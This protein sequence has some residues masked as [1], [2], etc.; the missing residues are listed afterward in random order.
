IG[1]NDSLE[2]VESVR[3][4]AGSL[5]RECWLAPYDTDGV[6]QKIDANTTRKRLLQHS[7][8]RRRVGEIAGPMEQQ[9]HLRQGSPGRGI[10]V[11]GQHGAACANESH[12]DRTSQSAART[13]DDD[14]RRVD[15]CHSG[16]RAFTSFSTSATVSIPSSS[17]SLSCRPSLSS[18]ATTR[19]T[20]TTE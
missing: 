12:D 15:R 7:V 13:S 1:A 5:E 11:E 16:G 8:E 2:A 9:V 14:P 6:D 3:S 17:A 10:D 18:I 4:K 20:I 19:R